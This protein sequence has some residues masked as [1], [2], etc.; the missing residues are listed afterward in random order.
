M[1]FSANTCNNTWQN[2]KLSQNTPQFNVTL[3]TDCLVYSDQKVNTYN[4]KGGK[5]CNDWS[6]PYQICYIT[7]CDSPKIPTCSSSTISISKAITKDKSCSVPKYSLN[8]TCQ[9]TAAQNLCG[10]PDP[11]T[12]LAFP[13]SSGNNIKENFSLPDLEF[14]LQPPSP[15]QMSIDSSFKSLSPQDK[16][17]GTIELNFNNNNPKNFYFTTNW[18]K[19]N[20][21][22][23]NYWIPSIIYGAAKVP[24]AVP[25]GLPIELSN[26]ICDSIL[27][28]SI[29][30]D[31]FTNIYW[32]TFRTGIST[33]VDFPPGNFQ[34]FYNDTN[35]Y[36][37]ANVQ[38]Y[39]ENNMSL[40]YESLYVSI[41]RTSVYKDF[42]QKLQNVLN[43]PQPNKNGS[44]YEIIFTV[45]V[46]V[47]KSNQN[48]IV[49]YSTTLLSNLLMESEIKIYKDGNTSSDGGSVQLDKSSSFSPKY[50]TLSG[51][52]DNY[53]DNYNYQKSFDNSGNLNNYSIQTDFIIGVTYTLKIKKWSV[54]TAYYFLLN[55][56]TDCDPIINQDIIQYGI[57][58]KSC[59]DYLKIDNLNNF[60]NTSVQLPILYYD[61]IDFSRKFLTSISE[62]CNCY[63][64]RLAPATMQDLSTSKIT[65]ACFNKKCTADPKMRNQ[66][67]ALN[68]TEESACTNYCGNIY[69]WFNGIA[70]EESLHP[71]EL[72][73]PTYE[74]ICGKNYQLN[75]SRNNNIIISGV[76]VTFFVLI[77]SGLVCW[78]KKLPA[79]ETITII[80]VSISISV[81]IFYL[82]S[83]EL[84]GKNFLDLSSNKP[85]YKNECKSKNLNITLPQDFCAF[86]QNGECNPLQKNSDCKLNTNCE[87]VCVSSSCIPSENQIRLPDTVVR[88]KHFPI[89]WLILGI[90]CIIL[91]PLITINIVKRF[92]TLSKKDY[93]IIW[94][95]IILASMIVFIIL[96]LVGQ[97]KYIKNNCIPKPP[98]FNN[99]ACDCPFLYYSINKSCDPNNCEN[100]PCFPAVKYGDMLGIK[101]SDDS[102]I[103]YNGFINKDLTNNYNDEY[104]IENIPQTFT[105]VNFDKTKISPYIFNNDFVY[106]K[107]NNTMLGY[108]K[109]PLPGMNNLLRIVNKDLSNYEPLQIKFI[110]TNNFLIQGMKFYLVD[111]DN[112]KFI[113]AQ[114]RYI[115]TISN[116]KVYPIFIGTNTQGKFDNK[117]GTKKIT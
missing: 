22:V 33:A 5:L 52:G 11:Q 75:P 89:T 24:K 17:P 117:P 66:I 77:L 43:L 54:L 101:Y 12:T 56:I 30:Q 6:D 38:K 114:N 4:D 31:F 19:K 35:W 72:D 86:S 59:Q 99:G 116:S 21:N 92:K 112:N 107:I 76:I 84:A 23:T 39:L 90:F 105:L 97:E 79:D 85:P 65:N 63:T 67:F 47:Y 100:C 71:D 57:L 102:L 36:S 94:S 80:L 29:T 106:L 32:K 83:N 78:N 26:Y 44:D 70:G 81:G 93:I 9:P 10:K 40:I 73:K 42:L 91:L 3:R 58:S 104:F 28:Y 34:N 20:N 61:D 50:L 45:P 95:S 88:E 69:S 62:D 16:I 64:A 2:I 48:K 115:G 60:C 41:N 27:I 15:A 109:S 68:N 7:K 8:C 18:V 37:K 87:G 53:D 1:F 25:E 103:K 98:K 51:T 96:T 111:K 55:N 108:Q 74:N 49:S 46:E 82:L 113:F 110:D 13:S 14:T